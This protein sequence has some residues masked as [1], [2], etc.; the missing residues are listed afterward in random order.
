MPL[1]LIKISSRKGP[2]LL[3]TSRIFLIP[4]FL[5]IIV[6]LS[7]PSDGSHGLLSPKSI[8]FFSAVIGFVL[9]LLTEKKIKQSHLPLALF[10]ISFILFLLIWTFVGLTNSNTPASVVA[11]QFKLFSITLSVP[12]MTYYLYKNQKISAEKML[13]M[14]V[15][16]NGAY[17]LTKITLIIFHLIGWVNI[18]DILQ[19]V[20]FKLQSMT[21]FGSLQRLQTSI[22]ISTPFIFMV[23]LF[24]EQLNLQIKPR[25]RNA[26]LA[27]AIISNFFTFSRFLFF[28]QGCAFLFYFCSLSFNKIQKTFLISLAFLI[29]T[30]VSVGPENITTSI[31][32]RF[33]SQANNQSDQTRVVQVNAL[34]KQH[35]QAPYL[36]VGL[37]G[38]VPSLVRDN[39][40]QHSYEVQWVAFLMQFGIFGVLYLLICVSMIGYSLLKPPINRTKLAFFSLFILWILSGFTNPFLISLQSGILYTLFLLA[41]WTQNTR[42]F[43]ESTK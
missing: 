1:L 27:L 12:L 26:Y 35:E 41:G 20:G 2:R 24:S 42:R 7:L 32:H 5:L 43:N 29:T 8:T 25:T 3:I 4:Y 28:V 15:Y 14:C 23:A 39:K 31:N 11:D 18:W 34:L 36:G 33:F 19:Q 22:D 37:G 38:H 40:N 9:Y 13:K 16:T 10:F 30:V 17:C 6:G 21:I